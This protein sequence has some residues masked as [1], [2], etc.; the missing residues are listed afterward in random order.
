MLYFRSVSMAG[1][2]FH[3]LFHILAFL[4]PLCY[5]DLGLILFRFS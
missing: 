2:L 3:L 5:L 4:F 1:P